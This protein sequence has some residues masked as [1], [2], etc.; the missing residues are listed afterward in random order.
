MARNRPYATLSNIPRSNPLVTAYDAIT[1]TLPRSLG[2]NSQRSALVVGKLA[3]EFDDTERI[4]ELLLTDIRFQRNAIV[5]ASSKIPPEVLKIIFELVA[6]ED[7]PH[8]PI[9]VEVKEKFM[10]TNGI[11]YN[12]RAGEGYRAWEDA[13]ESGSLGWVRLTHVCRYWRDI[14]CGLPALWATILGRLPLGDEVISKRA[15]RHSLVDLHFLS[16]S[17]HCEES[18]IF[19]RMSE[20]PPAFTY[21]TTSQIRALHLVYLWIDLEMETEWMPSADWS[22]LEMLEISCPDWIL[23][24]TAC[25]STRPIKAPRL[26]TLLLQHCFMPW[27]SNSLSR[28]SIVGTEEETLSTETLYTAIERAS[29]T[30]LY[31]EL[32]GVAATALAEDEGHISDISL[33]NLRELRYMTD[34]GAC[35]N[36]LRRVKMPPSALLALHLSM[37]A[38][39]QSI[40][41]TVDSD[42][43]SD[44]NAA[45][46]CREF[47]LSLDGLAI[48]RGSERDELL[49]RAY[50][51]ALERVRSYTCPGFADTFDGSSAPLA[52]VV[53]NDSA[54]DHNAHL[55]ICLRALMGFLD[56]ARFVTVSI[57]M[58]YW[59]YSTIHECMLLYTRMRAL[60]VVNPL[61]RP[62]GTDF[63]D[64]PPH[65]PFPF[66]SALPRPKFGESSD[67]NLSHSASH[68]ALDV[69]WL[70]QNKRTP[71]RAIDCARWCKTIYDQLHCTFD[72]RGWLNRVDTVSK[73]IKVLRI[74]YLAMISEDA[75]S[76]HE[77]FAQLAD[78]VE[79]RT[80]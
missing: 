3:N 19:S 69:L 47:G 71:R 1:L 14:L 78:V 13:M 42:M 24:P 59:N 43:A 66:L 67:E 55:D 29:S 5:P 62:D 49:L 53:T 36:L 80:R 77:I 54:K 8:A 50:C 32:A 17:Y 74:D 39:D 33:P 63:D 25:L 65:T 6:E 70:V 37:D 72:T 41:Q 52:L 58:P 21:P 68:S 22:N 16:S 40:G 26:R 23:I 57:E 61:R 28:L 51:N 20:P 9:D 18:H 44:I 2:G 10:D 76:A 73:P 11:R 38:N 60:R 56:P 30:L 79:W 64:Q 46:A 12:I 75:R 45:L 35:N 15:N 27:E 4:L 48:T 34:A 7:T 31:L